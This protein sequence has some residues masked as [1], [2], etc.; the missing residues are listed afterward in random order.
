MCN[1]PGRFASVLVFVVSSQSARMATVCRADGWSILHALQNFQ[2]KK[3]R[4]NRCKNHASNYCVW[5]HRHVLTKTWR[6]T[7]MSARPV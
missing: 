4:I 3:Q 2:Q 5:I 6:I 1:L 7:R